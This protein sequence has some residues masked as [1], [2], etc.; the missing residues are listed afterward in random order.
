MGHVED[1]WW[2][3]MPDGS[4]VGRDRV[5]VML[6]WWA[7]Y[8]DADGRHRSES[9]TRMKDAERF[10]V[11]V[12]A[13][14]QRGSYVDPGLSRRTLRACAELWLAAQPVRDSTRRCY[15][16]QLR[17]W[18]LPVLGFRSLQSITPTDVR[19][20]MRLLGERLAPRTAWHIHGLLAMILRAAVQDGWLAASRGRRTGPPR[21]RCRP[22]APFTVGQVQSLL[23]ALPPT[24]LSGRGVARRRLWAAGGGGVGPERGECR[25][26]PRPGAGERPTSGRARGAAAAGRAARARPVS[27]VCRCSTRWRLASRSTWPTARCS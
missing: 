14:L 11:L 2:R 21:P 13:D 7:W 15:D 1:R 12:R 27:G 3:V 23:A 20:W 9:F 22:V 6:R 24:G 26:G 17:T 25:C 5:G 16:S 18:S 10:L 4:R 8:R 19:A